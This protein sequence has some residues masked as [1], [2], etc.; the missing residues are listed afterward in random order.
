MNDA[1][2][3]AHL[4]KLGYV[5]RHQTEVPV[6]LSWHRAEPIPDGVDFKAEAVER[7]AGQ[8][9][10]HHIQ[11]TERQAAGGPRIRSAYL[12]ILG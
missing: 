2:M 4:Q 6:A 1:E 11:F 7:I 3:V 5:V 8:L 10:Q 9:L 12:R